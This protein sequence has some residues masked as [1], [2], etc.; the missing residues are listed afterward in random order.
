MSA[1]GIV[2]TL[3]SIADVSVVAIP[4]FVTSSRTVVS[5]PEITEAGSRDNT[6]E[7]VAIVTV[8]DAASIDVAAAPFLAWPRKYTVPVPEPAV[9]VQSI[10]PCLP[11]ARFNEAGVGPEE[12]K[13]EAE[14]V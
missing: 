3:A 2:V 14:P 1:T 4:E 5:P 12:S 11:A 9:Y 6:A 7:S 13:R 10:V 8:G